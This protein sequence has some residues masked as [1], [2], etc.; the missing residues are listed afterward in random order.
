MSKFAKISKDGKVYIDSKD[1]PN[2][3]KVTAQYNPKELQ[4]DRAV[5]WSPT[6]EANNANTEENK[7][8]HLEF[9]GAQGRSLTLELLFDEYEVQDGSVARN[10]KNLEKLAS[11]RGPGSNEED[12]RRPHWC[13]VVWGETLQSF[14]C[15]IESL[16][17]KYTMFS[18]L[19]APLR[20][21]CTVKLKEADSVSAKKKTP[22]PATGGAAAGTPSTPTRPGGT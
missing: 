9:T 20:A 1:E 16:S 18:P 11:V 8:I 2:T 12:L 14:Q 4:V 5:P 6:G 13:N 21:T 19:G 15:V 17:T 10:I 3:Y 22:P 7:G